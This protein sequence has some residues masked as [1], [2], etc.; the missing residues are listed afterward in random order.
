MQFLFVDIISID[1]NDMFLELLTGIVNAS[2]NTRYVSLSNETC[3]TQPTLI[4]LLP[5][6]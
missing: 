4:D 3:M 1:A 5:N 2:N 6:E